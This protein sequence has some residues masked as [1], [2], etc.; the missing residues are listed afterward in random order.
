[1]A[2]K[3]GFSMADLQQG[4][5]RLHSTNIS[6]DKRSTSGLDCKPA[7]EDTSALGNDYGISLY[8][9][10]DYKS[11]ACHYLFSSREYCRTNLC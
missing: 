7:A 4:A 2:S 6:E 9:F 10:I 3:S 1:M 5:K 11:I 8:T